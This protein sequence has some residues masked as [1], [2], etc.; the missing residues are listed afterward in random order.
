MSKLQ[1]VEEIHR[2]ARRNF[3]RRKYVMRGINDTFQADLVE[4]IP[5]SK[6]NNGYNYILMVIDVFSKRAWAKKLKNKTGKEV[7]AAMSSIFSEYPN[8]I[9]KNI[10]TDE[11][12][13]FYNQN[14]QELMKKHGINHYST[15]SKMKASI[16]E[17]FNRTILNKLWRQFNLQ[18][19][20]KW[21]N[22]IQRIIDEYNATYHR[23]IK[24]KPN[25]VNSK[26]ENKLLQ[27]VYKINESLTS[28]SKNKFKIGE[29][30]R[31][32]KF[33]SVV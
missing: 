9:P 4:M 32:S 10:H 16:V 29:Y 28:D 26:N 20:H 11:G 13:E 3:P 7:T 25:N 19:S 27:T 23:T 31:I 15:Y 33:K 2:N 12:K 22:N 6:E 14:F 1:V 24:M 30:V 21:L 18:G 17:R 5:F 8:H